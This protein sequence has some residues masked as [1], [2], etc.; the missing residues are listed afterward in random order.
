MSQR[1]HSGGHRRSAW[2]GR[3]YC[4]K[5]SKRGGA[6]IR[7]ESDS[8]DIF[9]SNYSVWGIDLVW[10]FGERE[11]H[12]ISVWVLGGWQWHSLRENR[13]LSQQPTGEQCDCTS[14]AAAPSFHSSKAMVSI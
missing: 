5:P 10:G 11:G 2:A 14:P 6:R 4:K 13:V 8:S 12:C 3:G 7:G 1:A 9:E